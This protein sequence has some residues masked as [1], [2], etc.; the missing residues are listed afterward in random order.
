MSDENVEGEKKFG[1]IVKFLMC[2][3]M[4][5]IFLVVGFGGG[6]FYFVNLMLFV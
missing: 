4:V 2:L 1:G 3:I 6:Y 5:I